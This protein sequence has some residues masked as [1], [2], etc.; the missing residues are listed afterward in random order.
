MRAVTLLLLTFPVSRLPSPDSV[1]VVTSRG[2]TA[3]PVSVE[4]GGPA[5]AA[6]LLV[7]PLGLTLTV[8]GASA[9]VI[10]GGTTFVFQ[11]GAPFARAGQAVC[12][13]A[14]APYVARDT[15]FLPLP[16]LADCL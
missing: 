10:V 15:L 12:A 3:I 16:W 13:L 8:T 7:D 1:F 14:A 2:A 9:T 6:Q 4:R 11:L 5:V